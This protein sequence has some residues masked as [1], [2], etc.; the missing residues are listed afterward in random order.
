MLTV[1]HRIQIPYT[2]FDFTFARSGGPG[3][4]NVNKVNTKVTL[5][6]AVLSSRTLPDDVRE[7]FMKKFHRR[8]T[9]D[10]DFLITSQRYRDQGRN[11]ADSLDK[12]RELLLEVATVPRTRKPTRRSRGSVERRI[13]EKKITSDRK[14]SRQ[15]P[16]MDD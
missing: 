9:K 10:G 2:E 6:W 7:R 12:L 5:R 1:N 4:Q 14:K 13:K 8:I 3:G 15:R 11:V 16:R